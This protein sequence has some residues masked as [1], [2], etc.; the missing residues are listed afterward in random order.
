MQRR[1]ENLREALGIKGG[2][3]KLVPH[4]WR[5]TAARLLADAGCT[6]SE[7]QA[8]TGHKTLAMVQKHRAQANQKDAT[9]RAQQRRD[10]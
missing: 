2:A 8:D 1:I 7:L 5:Y 3:D 9:K 6:Y 10:R 4:G